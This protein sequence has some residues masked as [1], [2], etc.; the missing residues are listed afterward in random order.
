MA[1]HFR[2]IG[3]CVY[4]LNLK[5]NVCT[6]YFQKVHTNSPLHRQTVSHIRTKR[7][8][9]GVEIE[10]EESETSRESESK[11]DRLRLRILARCHD[12]GRLWLRL[13]LRLCTPSSNLFARRWPWRGLTWPE[14]RYRNWPYEVKVSIFWC[15]LTGQMWWW[16]NYSR[17]FTK[18]LFT[19]GY[20]ADIMIFIITTLPLELRIGVS[21]L[22]QQQKRLY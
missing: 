9:V 19:K 6:D 1:P 13:R 15:V 8:G 22:P 17:I 7:S 21:C 3:K 10:F 18:R 14:V 2:L 11:F 4:L 5:D 16:L 12:P 20:S